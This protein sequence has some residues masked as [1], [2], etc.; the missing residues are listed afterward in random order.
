M[1]YEQMILDRFSGNRA[2]AIEWLE[3]ERCQALYIANGTRHAQTI[4]ECRDVA[5]RLEVAIAALKLDPIKAIDMQEYS[6]LSY[7]RA[8]RVRGTLQAGWPE[9]TSR[10]ELRNTFISLAA[11]AARRSLAARQFMGIE[12]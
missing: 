10:I 5:N 6:A 7:E 12:P 11:Q 3:T 1:T 2:K 8:A 4:A 9:W